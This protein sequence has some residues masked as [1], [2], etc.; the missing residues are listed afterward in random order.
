VGG[1]PPA[2]PKE[3]RSDIFKQTPPIENEKSVANNFITK[4]FPKIAIVL[5]LLV[6][7][8][9][10]LTDESRWPDYYDL[11]YM[12]WASLV[13]A[14][15]ILLCPKRLK[16]PLALVLM[17][18]A[19]GDLGLYELY[20]YGFEYD[21]VIHFMSPFIAMIVLIPIVGVPRAFLIVIAGALAWE[22]FEF[23]ADKFIKT[24][25]F[26]VYRHQIFRDTITDVVM[27]LLGITIG[28]LFH[29]LH[30]QKATLDD[31]LKR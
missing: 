11:P 16:L 1:I 22:S 13:C 5:F 29:R 10:L 14:L 25:L 7:I 19:S 31:N 9:L 27:N 2:E 18:N 21:K 8:I 20:K 23:L 6:G 12:G 15:L 26:G 28:I 17:F 3:F 30:S 24:H 4:I